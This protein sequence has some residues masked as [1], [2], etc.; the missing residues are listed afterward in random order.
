MGL[1]Q[2]GLPMNKWVKSWGM[3][4]AALLGLSNATTAAPSDLDPSFGLSGRGFAAV[5]GTDSVYGE[6]IAL[7]PGGKIVVVGR[8]FV[9]ATLTTHFCVIR[10]TPSGFFDTS[11]NL[12]GNKRVFAANGDTEIP[13]AV[14]VQADGKVVIAGQCGPETSPTHICVV[15]LLEDG[16]AD[17]GFG[18]S[19]KVRIGGNALHAGT[20]SAR[21]VN[22]LP[23]GRILV[24]GTCSALP[25]AQPGACVV[26][27]TPSGA[28]DAGF[29]SGG[30]SYLANALT[31]FVNG[32]LVLPDG[33]IIV[34]SEGDNV[35]PP[36][37]PRPKIHLSRLLDTGVYDTTFAGTG[38]QTLGANDRRN[39]L[40][41]VARQADGKVVVFYICVT[42]TS[43][44][45]QC[46]SRI[47]TNGS[48]DPAFVYLR[49]QPGGSFSIDAGEYGMRPLV[50][51][52][53]RLVGVG[54]ETAA[55]PGSTLDFQ[56]WRLLDDGTRDLSFVNAVY[57]QMLSADDRANDAVIQADDKVVLA[58]TC[59][60]GTAFQMCLARLQAG[61][62]GARN[63]T[64][65]IDGDGKVL[66]TT[67]ALLLARVS[68]G[69]SGTQVLTGLS[70]AG[71][72]NTWPLIR[73]YLVSQCGM[74]TI[75]P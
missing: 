1:Y 62:S 7:A 12:T 68:L 73:D 31:E 25:P 42:D 47:E 32:M 39:R 19:G 23:D 37:V 11:F 28:L 22:V 64:M 52:D 4:C 49:G 36:G 71:S 60:T 30:R 5:A 70:I 8:C 16:S 67:D 59:N 74:T 33:K 20:N 44:P 56:V 3:F 72:R 45:L 35:L 29:G 66:A 51:S 24:A 6:A 38:T 27:L 48:I 13:R 63:C 17:D 57:L 9:A 15:R 2:G 14:A 10:A 55:S 65:D 75:A 53:G 18:T 41:R 61:P 21:A 43:L 26:R 46:G 40:P 58:G 50:Q 54:S 69:L 34:V